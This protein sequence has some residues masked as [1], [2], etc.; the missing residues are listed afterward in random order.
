MS[1]GIRFFCLDYYFVQNGTE[2]I[3]IGECLYCFFPAPKSPTM[4]PDFP[5]LLNIYLYVTKP[6]S[7]TG[8]LAC[9]LPVLIPTSVPNPY[10]NPSANRVLALTKVPAES[11][12]RQNTDA[13]ASVSVTMQSVWCDEC[14]LIKLMADWR[15]GSEMT[16]RVSVRCSI[17]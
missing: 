14:A 11:T 5:L 6:S 13:A 17:V 12:L 8:P 15:E 16:E 7:P 2:L 9:I 4:C 3:V 1:L 10:L